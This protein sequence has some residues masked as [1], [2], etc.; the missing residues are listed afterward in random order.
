[1]A[2]DFDFSRTDHSGYRGEQVG[3]VSRGCGRSSG[4]PQES[5]SY[6]L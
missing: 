2:P 4:F 3:A 5:E 6:R 1:L